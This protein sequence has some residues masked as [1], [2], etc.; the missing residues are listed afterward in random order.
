MVGSHARGTATPTSDL[1]LVLICKNTAQYL[2]NTDWTSRFGQV[3]QQ[4]VEEYGLVISLRVWY[5]EGPEVEYGLTDERWAA[6]PLDEGTCRVMEDGIRIL[7]ERGNI[8][9]RHL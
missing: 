5:R 1:D 8:L 6:L 7:F 9:S 4:Q 2:H 3:E